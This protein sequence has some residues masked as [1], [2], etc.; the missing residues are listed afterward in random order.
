[1]AAQK[2]NETD[3]ASLVR[4][5]VE[6]D[7]AALT[8]L[9]RHAAPGLRGFL[10]ARIGQ[11]W[12]SVLE[13]DDVLQV[14]YLEAFLRVGT[15]SP[16]EGPEAA[17]AFLGWLR[18][19]ADNNLKDAIRGLESAKRPDPR[20]R[21]T[22]ATPEESFVALVEV[23]G[24]TSTTP[25]RVVAREEVGDL[26]RET[27]EQLPADYARVIALYD[28]QGKSPAEVAKEMGRTTGAVFMLRA[29]AHDRLKDL[30]GPESRFFSQGA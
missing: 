14:T 24:A 17:D 10:S 18:R 19:I 13:E 25:S 7:E 3:L 1:M 20:R 29:R 22:A 15:F 26:M 21:L 28:L 30:L 16:P 4:A 6:G 27:M 5:A 9:L 12:R 11:V 2:P 23:L 8:A